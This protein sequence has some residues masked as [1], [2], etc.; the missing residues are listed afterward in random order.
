MK[1]SRADCLLARLFSPFPV[2]RGFLIDFELYDEENRTINVVHDIF[3][4][5]S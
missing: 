2:A 4:Y 5:Y 3:T 1:N